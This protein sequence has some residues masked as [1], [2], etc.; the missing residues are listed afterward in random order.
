MFS[1]FPF[2]WHPH[3]WSSISLQVRLNIGEPKWIEMSRQYARFSKFPTLQT[4]TSSEIHAANVGTFPR[5]R[6]H[7]FCVHP[8]FLLISLELVIHQCI[9]VV[10]NQHSIPNL[11]HSKTSLPCHWALSQRLPFHS[12]S[13]PQDFGRLT[14]PLEFSTLYLPLRPASVR[15]VADKI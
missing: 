12:T 4:L 13:H 8:L 6:H 14:S 9:S 5:F 2:V 3:L 11:C 10:S 15:Q 1:F 7:F